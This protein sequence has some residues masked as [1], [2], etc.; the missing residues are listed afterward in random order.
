MCI[1]QGVFASLL[2][3]ALAACVSDPGSQ[4]S[5]ASSQRGSSSSSPSDTVTRFD[6]PIAAGFEAHTDHRE[7][8]A[9]T[10]PLVDP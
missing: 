8:P 4:T 9:S 5:D 3:I 10:P 1:R 2:L 7:L 6:G